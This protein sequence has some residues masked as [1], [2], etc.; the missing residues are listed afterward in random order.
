MKVTAEIQEA[1]VDLLHTLIEEHHLIEPPKGKGNLM[2]IPEWQK[3]EVSRRRAIT[4][5]EECTDAED[6]IKEIEQE[7]GVYGHFITQRQA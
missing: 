4:R 3:N 5:P 1:N 6:F 2:H 7:D